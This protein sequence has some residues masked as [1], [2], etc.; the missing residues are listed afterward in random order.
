M[1]QERVTHCVVLEL[2]LRISV[3]H[4]FVLLGEREEIHAIT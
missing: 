1:L 3:H 2:Q 4:M